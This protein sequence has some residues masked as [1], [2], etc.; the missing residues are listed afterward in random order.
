[1]KH[2]LLFVFL[3]TTC[4]G[5]SQTKYYVDNIGGD[6][7]NAG[8]HEN[9][10]FRSLEKINEQLFNPGDAILFKRGGHWTGI[11]KPQGN[12]TVG[13]RILIGS[14]GEGDLPIIDAEGQKGE[15]DFLSASL[16]LFNQEYWE[17]R[18]IEVR[19]FE[20]G[21]PIKPTKKAGILVL[22]KDIGTLH[23]FKFEN[24]KIS[25]V[26]GSL[27]TRINGG[28]FFNIIADSIP[29]KRI[30][31]NFNGIYVNNCYFSDVDRGG[32]VNQS[33]WRTRDMD[34]KFGELCADGEINNW[35]PSYNIV[36]ENSKFENVGGNGLVTR[37]AESPLVQYNLFVRCGS[38]TTGNA[39]YP[40]NCDNAL[41]QFNEASYTVY[42]E[43]DIDASGFDSDYLCKNTIIQYNYSH[44]NDWGGL[45][46]CSWGKVKNAFNDGTIVR[47]N[48]FQDEKHHMIRFSGNITNTEISNNLFVTDAEVDD[49]MMWYKHWG[50][51]WPDKTVVKDNVFYNEGTTHFLKLGETNNNSFSGNLLYGSEFADFKKFKTHTDVHK[52][53]EKG[54][55]LKIEQVR[56]IGLRNDFSVSEAEKVISTIWPDYLITKN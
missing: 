48:V 33:F 50:G 43:G 46:V 28:L 19:N 49:V 2:I 20:K 11:C 14:Y 24:L 23:D 56:K 12:G 31:T 35:Y 21:N 30:P 15:D 4:I 38:K 5:Q 29:E 54:L 39:S 55:K 18:D 26:N 27:R 47:Y 6:D 13:N 3:W 41:W 8:T 7:R 22:A 42:N 52:K 17:I 53:T 25:N 1:M 34:S 40:Y 16:I 37:V 32:F 36:I 9:L 51:I 45:L 10:P 44:H